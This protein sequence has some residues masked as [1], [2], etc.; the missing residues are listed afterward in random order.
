MSTHK[1]RCPACD[2]RTCSLACTKAH[3]Q[4][5]GCTG[6]RSR[7]DMVTLSD[8]TERQLLSDYK[9]LE[10]AARLNDVAQRSG[11]PRPARQLPHGLQIFVDQV[12]LTDSRTC[13]TLS[14]K[15]GL[16]HA[17]PGCLSIYFPP[18]CLT[19]LRFHLTCGPVHLVVLPC[20]LGIE[21]SSMIFFPPACTDRRQTAAG[22]RSAA[23]PSSGMCTGISQLLGSQCMIR[24]CQN[25]Y[26]SE[27]FCS[28]TSA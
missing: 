28:S 2:T 20:R 8:F 11:V 22:L 13:A 19:Y 17:L 7:T 26:H 23:R 25:R 10:E 14:C 27:R 6:K 15:S 21:A 18:C 4:A 24:E 16:P 9:F 3:K 1:Y 12:R 5:T